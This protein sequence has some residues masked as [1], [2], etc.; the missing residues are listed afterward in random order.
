MGDMNLVFEW[1]NSG[2]DASSISPPLVKGDR[3]EGGIR[4]KRMAKLRGIK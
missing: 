1:E 4:Q 3:G 2:E